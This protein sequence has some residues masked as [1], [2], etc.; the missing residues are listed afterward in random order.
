[1]AEQLPVLVASVSG[2]QARDLEEAS[3]VGR[4]VW[5]E[6]RW[7][8]GEPGPHLLELYTPGTNEPLCLLAEP[9]GAKSERGFALR[10]YPWEEQQADTAHALPEVVHDQFVGRSLANGRFEV[11]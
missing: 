8:P 4:D 11:V 6:L 10:V 9:L 7:A 2:Q 3:R 5:V 1:M